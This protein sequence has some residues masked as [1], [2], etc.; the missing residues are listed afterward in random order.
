MI[1]IKT[2]NGYEKI[3]AHAVGQYAIYSKPPGPEQ[4]ARVYA[5]THIASGLG[6]FFQVEIRRAAID[7]L[8][9]LQQI[10]LDT[11]WRDYDTGGPIDQIVE[12]AIHQVYED[13]IVQKK[14]H[15]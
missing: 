2:Y 1:T 3:H 7:A 4:S 8:R 5:I 15:C 9:D 12:R 10:D 13:H 14:E 11:A 6:I